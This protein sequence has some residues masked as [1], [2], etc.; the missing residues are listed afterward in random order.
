MVG[1]GCC[2]RHR[3]T[4]VRQQRCLT[5]P[6][7]GQEE[8]PPASQ[9]RTTGQVANQAS[10]M[11]RGCAEMY[12]PY[13]RRMPRPNNS[14][15]ISSFIVLNALC[16]FA[17]ELHLMGYLSELQWQLVVY[18]GFLLNGAFAWY[19]LFSLRKPGWLGYLGISFVLMLLVIA[20]TPIAA[21]W[22]VGRSPWT[23][24]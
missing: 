1:F 2:C 20:P 7:K 5:L 17:F 9:K 10:V 13:V 23:N 22:M 24:L 15:H 6:E 14:L 4:P 19:A 3:G 11:I 12:R 18:V 21:V 16:L 8:V